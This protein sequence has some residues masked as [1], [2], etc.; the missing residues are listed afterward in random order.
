LGTW[1]GDLALSRPGLGV[2]IHLVTGL[3]SQVPSFSLALLSL[4]LHFCNTEDKTQ[5]MQ[6]RPCTPELCPRPS[7]THLRNRIQ[8]LRI[9][10]CTNEVFASVH[11]IWLKLNR[12]IIHFHWC[13]PR[14]GLRQLE[15]VIS[16]L[17]EFTLAGKGL[18]ESLSVKVAEATWPREHQERTD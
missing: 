18:C 8:V 12:D 4:K 10:R 3:P 13:Q 15:T 16:V 2:S 17:V 14:G 7:V 6:S 9:G 1:W 5:G 11:P